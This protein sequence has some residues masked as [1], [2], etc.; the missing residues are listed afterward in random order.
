M[1]YATLDD[2]QHAAG[3]ERRLRELSD[4][5]GRGAVDPA[6]VERAIAIADAEIDQR[7]H[8]LYDVRLADPVPPGIAALSAEL[9]VLGLKKRRGG[10]TEVDVRMLEMAYER[11]GEMGKGMA[12]LGVEPDPLKSQRVVDAYSRPESDIVIRRESTKGYW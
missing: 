8:Q 9:A 3:G 2:V 5:T 12:T 11:L 4:W 6:E 7:L 10:L 1:G